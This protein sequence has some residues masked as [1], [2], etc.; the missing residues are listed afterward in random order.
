MTAVTLAIREDGTVQFLKIAP[1][2][3]YKFYRVR[4]DRH[5]LGEGDEAPSPWKIRQCRLIADGRIPD[6]TLMIV[7]DPECVEKLKGGN[8]LELPKIV[9][10][11]NMLDAFGGSEEKMH[12]KEAELLMSSL[13]LNII[14][15]KLTPEVKHDH[16]NKLV[17]AMANPEG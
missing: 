12:E 9:M 4:I 15:T 7:F 2:Q 11:K 16:Q 17:I 13:D 6:D 10:K 1:G 5:D 14:H 8:S 3:K